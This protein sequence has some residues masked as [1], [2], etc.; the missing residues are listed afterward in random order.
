[1]KKIY[2]LI[3]LLGFLINVSAQKEEKTETYYKLDN[4]IN[5][6][7][8][9]EAALIKEDGVREKAQ[10]VQFKSLKAEL[11]EEYWLLTLIIYILFP[12]T[13]LALIVGSYK[14]YKSIDSK[15]EAVVNKKV[16]EKV[17]EQYE[18]VLN[19]NKATLLAI[20]NQKNEE[21]Q[22]R[23]NK[24]IL[25]ISAENGSDDF[26]KGFFTGMGFDKRNIIYRKVNKYEAE[27]AHYDVIFAN[28][29]IKDINIIRI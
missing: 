5:A 17:E 6:L 25:V 4:R 3:V 27:S 15:T 28:N 23:Q 26:L 13:A 7:E 10:E 12:I 11:K 24:R 19:E 16:K 18:K 29:L 1:M 21:A 14:I 9:N 20:V 8:R 2:L 22:L